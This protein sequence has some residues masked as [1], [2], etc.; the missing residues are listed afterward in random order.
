MWQLLAISSPPPTTA[1]C[2][3]ATTGTLPNWIAS[4]AACQLRECKMPS[5][6][7]RSLS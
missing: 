6:T 1:P 3:T 7:L 2:S 4:I 5:A